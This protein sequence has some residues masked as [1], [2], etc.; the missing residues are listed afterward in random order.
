LVVTERGDLTIAK[1]KKGRSGYVHRDQACW[2]G[3][4]RKK[5]FYRAFH[6]EISKGATEKIVHELRTRWE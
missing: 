5:S 4:L 1:E 3:L 6:A 2:Q